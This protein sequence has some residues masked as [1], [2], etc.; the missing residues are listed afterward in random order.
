MA[1]T[2]EEH[3]PRDRRSR[4][5]SPPKTYVNFARSQTTDP[6]QFEILTKGRPRPPHTSENHYNRLHN[7]CDRQNGPPVTGRKPNDQPCRESFPIESAAR[8]IQVRH[9]LARIFDLQ[10]FAQTLHRVGIG[11]VEDE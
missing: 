11:H 1:G 5:M 9:C 10:K 8:S 6:R 3:R 2:L 7:R 4:V